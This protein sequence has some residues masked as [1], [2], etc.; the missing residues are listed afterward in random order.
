MPK[1]ITNVRNAIDKVVSSN[2]E[3]IMQDLQCISVR[4]VLQPPSS[5]SC[6][7]KRARADSEDEVETERDGCGKRLRSNAG[8]KKT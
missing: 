6:F 2:Q 3:C 5:P 8:W 4:L 7:G 1:M